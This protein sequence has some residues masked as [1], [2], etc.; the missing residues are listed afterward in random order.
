M[1][2][3]PPTTLHAPNC[4]VLARQRQVPKEGY[5]MSAS[6]YRESDPIRNMKFFVPAEGPHHV[7]V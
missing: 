5:H 7:N 6:P 1:K 4:P 3:R 2:T